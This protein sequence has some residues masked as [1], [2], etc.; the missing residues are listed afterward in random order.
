[1]ALR[2]RR[3]RATSRATRLVGDGRLPRRAG[4]AFRPVAVSRPAADRARRPAE[5]P[6]DRMAADVTDRGTMPVTSNPKP[7]LDYGPPARR[8]SP[9]PLLGVVACAGG[10]LC[11]I[12]LFAFGCW[13]FYYGVS[14][15]AGE[16]P[17]HLLQ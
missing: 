8:P 15:S 17:E 3:A 11:G 9:V 1:M 10:V 5:L 12:G 13:Q 16:R 14:G 7:I 4:R 6:R 2:D